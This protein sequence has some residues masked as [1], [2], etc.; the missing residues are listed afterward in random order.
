MDRL[1]NYATKDAEAESTEVR[2][3]K[4]EEGV[5]RLLEKLALA[6]EEQ[7][8]KP[9]PDYAAAVAEDK[10]TENGEEQTKE[11]GEQ[12][13]EEEPKPEPHQPRLPD[14][15][16]AEDRKSTRLNSSH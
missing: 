16:T 14:P 2:L 1:S 7:A 4:E 12:P 10:P 11:D 13:K 9:V 6:A 15:A 8:S 3:R 5:H